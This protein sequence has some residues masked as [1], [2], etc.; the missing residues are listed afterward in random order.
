MTIATATLINGKS[1]PYVETPY[2]K[3]GGMKTVYFTPDNSSAIAFFKD[4]AAANDANRLK[5]LEAVLGHYNPT[6][7]K[8]GDYWKQL[9]CWPTAIVKKPR[10]G[11]VVPHYSTIPPGSFFFASG[12]NRGREKKGAW[13][14]RQR[15][16]SKMLA[17]SPAELGN[18]SQFLSICIRLAR[19]VRRLH[20]AGLAHSDLSDN[21]VLVDPT[22]GRCVMIDIDSLVVPTLFTPDVIGTP[23]YI[24]PEVL[25]TQNLSLKDPNRNHPNVRTDLHA[26]PVLLYE[27]LFFRHPLR[28]GPKSYPGVDGQQQELL[29]L[30]SNALFKEHPHDRSNRPSQLVGVIDDLGPNLKSLFEKAFIGGLQKPND[31]PSAVAWEKAL[32]KIWDLRHPCGNARCWQRWFIV[33]GPTATRCPHCQTRLTSPVPVLK[34]RKEAKG[35]WVDDGQIVVHAEA[36]L[37]GW[38]AFDNSFPGEHAERTPLGKFKFEGGKWFFV[39]ERLTSLTSPTGNPVA[40]GQ[41]RGVELKPGVTFR[42]SNEPN[43]RMAEIVFYTV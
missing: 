26:L 2:P 43:G 30:G 13:F 32:M 33:H 41:N 35:K 24:A 18:W 34:L 23:G 15:H 20:V 37:F 40:P 16:R 21:N 27:Y 29:E 14:S 12:P 7:G 11:V 39:N 4:P 10:L 36:G 25:R 28:D 6:L 9:F 8:D 19:A 3:E 42:L 17:E 22:S 31:R 38:H 5:R 1:I